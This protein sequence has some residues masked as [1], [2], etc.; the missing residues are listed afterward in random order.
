MPLLGET[1]EASREKRLERQQARLRD[2]GGIFKPSEH[3]PL[4]ELLLARGVNGESLSRPNSPRRSR[5]RSASP[6]RKEQVARRRS[7]SAPPNKRLR[8]LDGKRPGPPELEEEEGAYTAAQVEEPIAG[9]SKPSAR[10]KSAKEPTIKRAPRKS[11]AQPAKPMPDE[12]QDDIASKPTTSATVKPKPKPKAATKGIKASTSAAPEPAPKP[13]R[14]AKRKAPSPESEP[15]PEPEP[16]THIPS[17]D[18][19]LVPRKKARTKASAAPKAK[20]SS[21]RKRAN[22]TAEEVIIPQEV[23]VEP[24]K[25]RRRVTK[26]AKPAPQLKAVVEEDEEAPAPPQ[27][28]LKRLTKGK[29]KAEPDPA[30]DEP[31]EE[32]TEPA[33]TAKSKR[34]KKAPPEP[35]DGDGEVEAPKPRNRTRTTDKPIKLPAARKA[36]PSSATGTKGAQRARLSKVVEVPSDD[37]AVPP[38]PPIPRKGAAITP[39]SPEV[40]LAKTAKPTKPAA[41]KLLPDRTNHRLT[42]KPEDEAPLLPLKKRRPPEDRDVSIPVKSRAARSAKLPPPSE[43]PTRKVSRSKAPPVFAP[44]GT[45][46]K[47][48]PKPRMSMFPAPED[49]GESDKDPIDFLS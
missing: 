14:V 7:Q 19:P 34:L 10:T 20:A 30:D 23:E 22:T 25:P 27:A 43:S 38:P 35:A 28:R 4:V 47:P 49:D 29:R 39:S 8:K 33:P 46:L 37:E 42:E 24:A 5:S 9:P 36:G 13:K 41:S 21:S 15:E 31:P 44:K 6:S 26:K 2:R 11:R 45:V 32:E 12:D 17:D 18:E 1:V 3:N 48:K 40:A 16:D